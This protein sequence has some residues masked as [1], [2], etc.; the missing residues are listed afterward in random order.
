MQ[1]PCRAPHH[2]ENR[3]K[4]KYPEHPIV[5]VGGIIFK[6]DT[7][8]LVKRDQEPGKGEW[9]LPGGMVEVGETLEEA[10]IR[11]I[12][13]E[14]GIEIRIGGLARLLDRIIRDES[15]RVQYH[16][17]I[18]DYWA[19]MVSGRPRPASDVS[20]V[21]FVSPDELMHMGVH[22]DVKETVCM[23]IEKRHTA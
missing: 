14:V 20:D 13:E 2:E 17:V 16:F 10:L 19:E 21:R 9:S 23:A 8:L 12:T 11:E 18:V 5:G 22:R 15:Q 4:R 7:V 3:V 1:E 6:E